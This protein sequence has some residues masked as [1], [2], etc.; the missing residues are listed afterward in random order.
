MAPPPFGTETEGREGEDAAASLLLPV[1]ATFS[2]EG[3]GGWPLPASRVLPEAIVPCQM[4][5]ETKKEGSK[6][7]LTRETRLSMILAGYSPRDPGNSELNPSEL[8]PQ[9]RSQVV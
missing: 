3:G 7:L 4:N 9:A 6:M 1:G 2:D 5:E 8:E